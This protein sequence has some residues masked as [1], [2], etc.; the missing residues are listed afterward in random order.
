MS[1]YVY[2]FPEGNKEMRSLLGNKGA[3]LAEMTNM[4][5][6]VPPGFTITTEVCRTY[7]SGGCLPV[8]LS[9]EVEQHLQALESSAGSP[10]LVSVRSGAEF[11]M[12]GM[13]D[14]VLNV[15]CLPRDQLKF[16]IEEVFRSWNSKRARDYR[17]QH[18]IPDDL[19]T[20]VTVQTM[21]FGNLGKDS[22]TG[23]VF[24]RNP[25]NG[26]KKPYGDYLPNAQGEEV[27]AG[28]RNTLP[29]AKLEKLDSL[30]YVSLHKVMAT[31]EAHYRDM[32]DIEFTIEKGKLWILQTRVGKRTAL[33]EWIMA[34]D[35]LEEGLISDAEALLRIDATR[36]E[37]L[38]R[39]IMIQ[40]AVKPMMFV[41]QGLGV[42]PGIAV[43]RVSFT[44][45]AAE[46]CGKNGDKVILVRCETMP[47]DYHGM[48]AS[49]GILTST[50]GVNSHAAVVARSEGIPAVC[51]ADKIHINA[52]DHTFTMNDTT[53]IEGDVITID[54]TTGKVFIGELPLEE[55]TLERA[56]RGDPKARSQKVWK[57]FERLT[58]VADA[59]RLLKVYANADTCEQIAYARERGA[60]G[61]GLCRTEHMFLGE[62]RIE[63]VRQVILADTLDKEEAAYNTLLPLQRDDFIKIFQTLGGLPITIRLL[64][65]PLYEFL[66]SQEELTA[67]LRL[68][69]GVWKEDKES[70]QLKLQKVKELHKAYAAGFGTIVKPGLYVMQVRAVCEA[71]DQ[72]RQNSN[73]PTVGIILP[74]SE[75]QQMRGEFEST[76]YEV[77]GIADTPVVFRPELGSDYTSCTPYEVEAVR[78]AAGQAAVLNTGE[79]SA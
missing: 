4:G 58:A 52:K 66:P 6:P 53:V 9:D 24:T 30:S 39:P 74:F 44:A 56:R 70:L 15:P 10:I 57:A 78:L 2:D 40:Q 1:K 55:A 11:S 79:R 45:D 76:V 13:M 47:S 67:G 23:V 49:Q 42:S 25:S 14:T 19:G 77:L 60:D 36:L 69:F 29:F 46:R 27:V 65:L 59:R 31:L 17:R 43:G 33:G 38:S 7:L 34:H 32:C 51:G 22:G 61:I 12:P 68:P 37:E 35:M 54:G 26:D 18:T 48:I 73:S 3:N 20:A 8:E 75:L 28:L 5:L 64:S 50:G 21:V 71:L 41:T 16:T 62:E 72:I 63:A